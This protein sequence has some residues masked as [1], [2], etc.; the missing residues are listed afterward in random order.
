MN[1]IVLNG[2][3][4]VLGNT[5]KLTNAFLSGLSKEDR[6]KIFDL[7]D[8]MPT[9]CNACGYCKASD[10]CSKKDLEEFLGYYNEADVVVVAT[11]VYNFSLPAPMKAL[12]D[13]FQ[14]FYEARFRRGI[15]NAVEKPKK[16]VIIVTAGSDGKIGYEVIKKQISTAFSVMNTKIVA[17]MLLSDTDTKPVSQQD[18]IQAQGLLRYI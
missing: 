4:K 8:I 16:A 18:L 5:K 6:V 2:S 15:E 9:P 11:P 10:G 3:P 17:S 14:R 12:F 7:F 13:R 1:V